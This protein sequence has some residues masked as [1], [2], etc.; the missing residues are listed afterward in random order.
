MKME[1]D[2]RRKAVDTRRHIK[3]GNRG[4]FIRTFLVFIV[5]FLLALVLVGRLVYL[6]YTKGSTYE[7]KVLNQKSYS[8]NE[9]AYR[10]GDITDRNG[11][12]LATSKRVYDLVIDPGLILQEKEYITETAKAL[13]KVFGISQSDLE[14]I[15]KEQSDT[16]YYV[17]KDFKGLKKTKVKAFNKLKADNKNIKG[18][19][20]DERYERYYPYSTVASKVLG[21]CTTDNTGVWG[22]ESQY[23]ASLNGISGKKYGYFNTDLD[24]VETVNE[25]VNGNNIESTIDVNVQGILERH[26]QEFQKNTGSKNMGC[27]IMNPQNGEVYAMSSY[28]EYNLNNPRDLSVLYSQEK[29]DKMSDK[30]KSEALNQLWRNYCISDAFEP[31]STFKPMTVAACL[32]EGVTNPTRTYECNGYQVVNGVRIKCVA[33]SRGGHGHIDICHSLMESCNDVLM[34]LGADL[35]KTKFLQYVNEFGFGKKTGIDLPG[36]A[37]GG[38]FTKDTMHAVELATSSFGQGQ[39]VT[40]IQMAAAFSATINGGNYY[41]PHVVKEVKSESGATVSSNDNALVR[42]VITENTSKKIRKYLYK[43]V[44]EG[45]AL[46]AQ[47]AGYE[48]G[49]KTGTAEKHPTGRGNYLVSFIGFASQENPEVMIYVTIDE[50]KVEDQAH[51]SYA[52]QFSSEVLKEVLP[53]LGMYQDSD[54]KKADKTKATDIQLPST[55]EV[56]EGG[57]S[58]SEYGVATSND[59]S[60]DS[61]SPEP[62]NTAEASETPKA[63]SD[64]DSAE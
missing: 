7:K 58:D 30:K 18:V 54:T 39:T 11:N 61:A 38:V 48:I 24:L 62:S 34:Q 53:I 35:G 60:D 28:P 64:T 26:M 31:G 57:Y 42:R 22:I 2:M 41:E 6:N 45:T 20:F 4:M 19:T 5:I 37:S 17:M 21:F 59:E 8:T 46:P 43:T 40:M 15:I 52:T 23:N 14:K 63:S 25:P 56:P 32:D 36:E 13:D 49:G 27:I 44:E 33:Y 10:R 29:I 3:V 47:V 9:I 12:K 1:E 55:Q 50:P 51:S 16:H